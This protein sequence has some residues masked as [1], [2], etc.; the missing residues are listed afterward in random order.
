MPRQFRTKNLS[1]SLN[2][3]SKLGQLTEKLR[4]CVLN[5][6][7]CLG[8]T[9]CRLLTQYCYGYFSWCRL[10]T[11]RFGT[12]LCDRPYSWVA[13]QAATQPTIVDC[14]PGSIVANPGDILVDPEI[15]VRQIAELRADLQEAIRQLDVHEK[16]IGDV[17]KEG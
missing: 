1:V 3:S 16:E 13:C 12:W 6:H 7:I 4:L 5:T 10:F 11:C 14:G 2:P 17:T 15:Y 8:W 9:N